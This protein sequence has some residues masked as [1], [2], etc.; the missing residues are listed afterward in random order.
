MGQSH[1][2]GLESQKMGQSPNIGS[3]LVRF[4]AFPFR[5][6]LASKLFTTSPQKIGQGH[7]EALV[8]KNGSELQELVQVWPSHL[9]HS[10]QEQYCFPNN[11]SLH[12]KN[13]ANTESVRFDQGTGWLISLLFQRGQLSENICKTFKYL[14]I[15]VQFNHTIIQLKMHR[16]KI[17][18]EILML[19]VRVLPLFWRSL[20]NLQKL[21]QFGKLRRNAERVWLV[22]HFIKSLKC[23]ACDFKFF[24]I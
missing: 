11:S 3:Q 10:Y 9:Y 13:G 19:S 21:Q 4:F 22:T 6:N 12:H 15:C 1:K 24:K 20:K 18:F 2:N 17:I 7:K 8:T 14:E 5:S 23:S 16:R